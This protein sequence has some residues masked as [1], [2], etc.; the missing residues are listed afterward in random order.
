MTL[1]EL[2]EAVFEYGHLNHRI[3]RME[4]DGQTTQKKYNQ[5]VDERDALRSRL[6]QYF[7]KG[8]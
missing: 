1:S 7:K 2:E 6:L 3:G 4:T 5:S 8:K